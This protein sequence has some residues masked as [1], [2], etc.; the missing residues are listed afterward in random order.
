MAT[1]VRF[2]I[3]N[4]RIVRGLQDT[5]DISASGKTAKRDQLLSQWK[6]YGLFKLGMLSVQTY[7]LEFGNNSYKILVL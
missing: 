2:Y 7:L 5:S 1:H 3:L 4:H 6:D